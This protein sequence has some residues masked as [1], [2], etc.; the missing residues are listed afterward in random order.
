MFRQGP[1]DFVLTLIFLAVAGWFLITIMPVLFVLVA[2]G[3][4][5]FVVLYILRSFT[6]WMK[7]PP[8]SKHKFDDDGRRITSIE[9]LEM[10]DAEPKEAPRVDGADQSPRVDGN[11]TGK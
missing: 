6:A 5:V 4:L 1:L 3:I 10:T 7:K 9:V 11:Q 8:A 2:G